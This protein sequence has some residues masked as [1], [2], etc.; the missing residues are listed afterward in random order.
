MKFQ[1]YIIVKRKIS[2]AERSKNNSTTIITTAH[3]Y[4]TYKSRLSLKV[5]P[6]ASTQTTLYTPNVHHFIYTITPISPSKNSTPTANHDPAIPTIQKR[7]S[8]RRELYSA[9][10][11]RHS[12]FQ[13]ALLSTYIYITYTVHTYI[14]GRMIS[15]ASLQLK[16][17]YIH[18]DIWV[19][20]RV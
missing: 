8:P 9:F 12:T 10:Q 3:C 5:F 19:A 15:R 14:H 13:S 16:V 18:A 6:I 1:R 2:F 7:P 11:S 20:Y 4:I 17:K